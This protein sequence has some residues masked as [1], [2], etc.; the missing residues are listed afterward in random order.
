MLVCLDLQKRRVN[1]NETEKQIITF[2][3][4]YMEGHH[5]FAHYTRVANYAHQLWEKEGGDWEIIFAAIWL[6]DIGRKESIPDHPK[7]GATLVREFLPTIDFPANKVRAVARAILIHDDHGAQQTIEEK[8]VY[9]ADRLDC[10]S[11]SG[12]LRCFLEPY[13]VG[14]AVTFPE[15][16][17]D[18]EDYL[19]VAFENLK[20]KTAR[21][22]ALKY[23]REFLDGFLQRIKAEQ[24]MV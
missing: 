16:I 12:L 18:A 11:Y 21:Q 17:K 20:T 23:R 13:K 22:I 3:R 4:P 15:I 7:V 9:D 5:D 2:A 24:E 8:I 1:V 6:H 14:R 10:F 19:K